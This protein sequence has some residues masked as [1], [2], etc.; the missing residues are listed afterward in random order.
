VLTDHDISDEPSTIFQYDVLISSTHPEYATLTMLN[1][2]E[3]FVQR[4]GR[5][6]YLGGNGYY[7]VTAHNPVQDHLIEVRRAQS[8]CRSFEL[9]PGDRVHSLTGEQGGLW[10]DRGKPPSDVFGVGS[11]A[12]SF[13]PGIPVQPFLGQTGLFARPASGDEIDCMQDDSPRFRDGCRII[14]LATTRSDDQHHSDDYR[15]FPEETM[16]P[17]DRIKGS[18]SLRVRSDIVLVENGRGMVFSVGSMDWVGRRISLTFA[19]YRNPANSDQV[20]SLF[21]NGS[22]TRELTTNVLQSFRDGWVFPK[23]GA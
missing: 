4:G 11:V 19:R 7:W 14:R 12:C 16:F 9:R 20:F 18:E 8:G 3:H 21:I 17:M 23:A 5:M 22:Y 15:L 10:R 1:C 13:N 6:M 2:F